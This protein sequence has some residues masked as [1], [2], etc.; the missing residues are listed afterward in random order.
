[1]KVQLEKS[2]ALGGPAAAAWVLLQD[3]EAVAAC[4][5]GARITEKVGP[6]DIKG[7]VT[8]RMGPASLVFRGEVQVKDV[9]DEARSLFLVGRGTDTTGTSGAAMD[10]RAHIEEAGATACRL[11]GAAEV[12]VSGKAATFGGRLMSAVADQVLQQFAA[13]FAEKLGSVPVPV[14]VQVPE[15][16]GVPAAEAVSVPGPEPIPPAPPPQRELNGFALVWAML[17]DWLHHLFPARRA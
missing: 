3:L 7:T 16:A 5:P 12:S 6:R 14:P 10:L 13:N 9:D 4:M 17:R 2:F 1:M 8:V 15:E 11:V